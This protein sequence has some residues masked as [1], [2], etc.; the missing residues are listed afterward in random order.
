MIR[1][2]FS[3]A[4]LA[5]L[6]APTAV[7]TQNEV[8]AGFTDLRD[9]D[10]HFL[11][12]GYTR[13]LSAINNREGVHLINPYLQR[14]SS[15]RVNYFALD[16][17]DY[18]QA[19]GTWY[20]NNDWM[21][22]ADISYLDTD[23]RLHDEDDKVADLKAGFNLNRHVQVGTGLRYHRARDT[24]YTGGERG[25]Q[26]PFNFDDFAA[27][28]TEKWSPSAFAR[29]TMIHNG[30]GW[31]FSGQVMFDD[32]DTLEASGRY[33]FSPGLSAAINYTF[34]DPSSELEQY[35]YENQQVVGAEVDYW[36]N[37]NWSVRAGFDVGV[38]GNSGLDSLTLLS[39]YRF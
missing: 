36:V 19:G 30:T 22:S 28:T 34:R 17:I 33:F 6:L 10:D 21:L 5:T 9:A 13:Y 38:Q 31:D 23:N 35:G 26:T 37:P 3:V 12:I 1:P 27:V 7:A 16:D 32:I 20:V 18:T 4:V 8:S 15:V 2:A 14:I 29:Y 25:P 39:T 24:Y 11:G